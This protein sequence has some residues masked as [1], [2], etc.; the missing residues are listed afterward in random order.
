MNRS[1]FI[2]T[3]GAGA[4]FLYLRPWQTKAFA[5]SAFNK[6]AFGKNFAWG[7]AT[8][9]YQIEGGATA[10]GRG[11][12]IWDVFS[13]RRGKIKDKSTGDVTCDFFHRYP[14]DLE[15]LKKL[16][17]SDFRFSISWSRILP[18]GTGAVNAK[19]VDFYNRIIDKCLELNI[20]PW[21]NLYHWDLPQ[22]LEDKGGWSNR[23]II[24]WFSEFAGV[25]AD[26]FGDRVKNWLV[27][28]E[29]VSFTTFGYLTGLHAPGHRSVHR[30]LAAI[31][32]TAMCQAEGGRVLRAKMPEARIGTAFSCSQVVPLKDKPSHQRAVKRI[33]VMVNRLFVEPAMGMG[34]PMADLPFLKKM[35]KY[36]LPGDEEKLKFEFD[37]IGLQNYFRVIGRPGLIPYVW[38][39][40]VK[41]DDADAEFTAMDWEVYPEGIYQCIKNFAK[42]P[43]KEIVISET[44]AAFND[45]VNDGKIHDSQR[46]KFLQQYLQNVLKAK[47]E[48]VN[49][50]GFFVWT[51]I[52]NFEW[53]E[54]CRPRFGLVYNDFETQE[55]IVKDSGLWF[56]E[57]LK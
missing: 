3:L 43:V 9:A 55:R 35:E 54:G 2:K 17:F 49:V 7:V 18:E 4:A 53:A 52:D 42:Y 31:H 5:P 56:R 46:I 41:P 16:N 29:P 6:A 11:V 25:C 36:I 34:Y 13:H 57:F 33:D 10:D 44:G 27:I 12:S 19:G 26:K 45:V 28:N 37:F 32:H 20:T 1:E 22:A 30:F 14:Q 47:N 15:L 21:I 39:G 48:G 23:E 38:A 40:Y 24:E 51:F 8:A 50:T